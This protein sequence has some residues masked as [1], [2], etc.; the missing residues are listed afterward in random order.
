MEAVL[1][2]EPAFFLDSAEAAF[3]LEAADAALFLEAA[4]AAFFFDAAETAFFFDADEAAF[5][6]DA[7]E[8]AF[9]FEAAEEPF[10]FEATGLFETLR[11]LA[12]ACNLI[13]PALSAAF[14][15]LERGFL[16]DGMIL[17]F[18]SFSFLFSFWVIK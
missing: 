18:L 13:P 17:F 12:K 2:T 4:E 15:A 16:T 11:A 9:F 6:F 5:F 3:F 7:A 1:F 14:C 10:L 8:A